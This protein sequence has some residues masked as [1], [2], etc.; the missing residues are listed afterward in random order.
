MSIKMRLDTAG[1]RALIADNPELEVEIGKEVLKNIKDGFVRETIEKALE[2]RVA[3]IMSSFVENK[4]S[5]WQPKYVPVHEGFTQVVNTLVREVIKEESERILAERLQVA[6]DGAIQSAQ[7]SLARGL[8]AM[9]REQ[10]T[11]ELAKEI[12]R[13]KLL[14]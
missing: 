5:R 3:L 14:I 10:I 13:E 4:G 1:L 2:G 8:H 9:L 7:I 6:V 12:I 11:P